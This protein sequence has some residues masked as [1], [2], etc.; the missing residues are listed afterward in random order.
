[1][2]FI[3]RVTL[4]G[5]IAEQPYR[6]CKGNNESVITLTL[7]TPAHV[8]TD[9]RQHRHHIWIDDPLKVEYAYT[10]ISRSFVPIFS[11]NLLIYFTYFHF[12]AC[13]LSFP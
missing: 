11:N 3:N 8:G 6:F 1:M 7:L 9:G 12:Y 2:Y 13:F 4:I 10:L 5:H